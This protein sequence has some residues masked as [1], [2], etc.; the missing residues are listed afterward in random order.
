[1]RSAERCMRMSR[2][3]AELY[4]KKG[5]QNEANEENNNNKSE[6]RSELGLSEDVEKVGYFSF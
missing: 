6:W 4:E 2:D 5:E 3:R 1:M